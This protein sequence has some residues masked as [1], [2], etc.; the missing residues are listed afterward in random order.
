MI[1]KSDKTPVSGQREPQFSACLK[2]TEPK[3]LA[4]SGNMKLP[5]VAISEYGWQDQVM[6]KTR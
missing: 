3:K 2:L 4:I 6:S 5:Y 1:A